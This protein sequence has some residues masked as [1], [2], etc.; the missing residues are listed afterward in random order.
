[1]ST[2]GHRITFLKKGRYR[3]LVLVELILIGLFF[4]ASYIGM[5]P[6]SSAV[7]LLPFQL[8]LWSI[9][10][11]RPFWTLIGF[12]ALFPLTGFELLP[13]N[14][15]LYIFYPMT[16]VLLFSF[17]VMRYLFQEKG[18]DNPGQQPHVNRSFLWPIVLLGLW[19]IITTVHAVVTRIAGNTPLLIQY[20]YLSL[21]MLTVAFF[22][23]AYLQ[24]TAQI[25][26]FITVLIISY[27]IGTF[28]LPLIVLI[29]N[30]SFN[31][32]T[33]PA[34]FGGFINMNA[35]GAHMN[36]AV[37]LLLGRLLDS[38]RWQERLL[39]S[40]GFTLLM[41]ILLITR[42]RGAWLGF[43]I[44]VLYLYFKTRSRMLVTLMLTG[45][46]FVLAS[47]FVRNAFVSRITETSIT[48]PSLAGRAMLWIA[49]IKVFSRNWLLGVGLENF[50]YAK[51]LYG[52]PLPKHF[53]V[54]FNTHNLF[55][56]VLTDLG[57][58]GLILFVWLLGYTVINLERLS[59]RYATS[60]Y[61]GLVAGIN[62]AAIG[63]LIHGL[64]DCLTWQH[65]AF[66]LLGVVLGLGGAV[67]NCYRHGLPQEPPGN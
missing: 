61:S 31:A 5:K 40:A 51:H 35:V 10:M 6:I 17:P 60:A 15:C 2:E 18:A 57:L 52:F 67:I 9:I 53:A 4:A 1:M 38:R 54:R 30:S 16:L 8:L 20:T 62:A 21:V 19:I 22:I 64:W 45:S 47:D 50:R 65:G 36:V 14:Y 42:S 11:E 43:G 24:N 33:L 28:A 39:L 49:A 7:L 29:S 27:A 44:G 32:K 55:L 63:Y 56:E 12:A 26:L 25:R 3:I 46:I 59:K 37:L 41:I 23:S 66:I 13:Y 48:D 34:P 58:I